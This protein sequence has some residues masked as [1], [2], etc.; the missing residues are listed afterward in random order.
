MIIKGFRA[1]V[2]A[3]VKAAN[4]I[5]AAF[6]AV[7]NVIL[8][9][10]NLI[11]SAFKKVAHAIASVANGIVRLFAKAFGPIFNALYKSMKPGLDLLA[12]AFTATG[13]GIIKAHFG[14]RMRF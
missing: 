11:A 4:T 8:A 6:N 13:N 9:C 7:K 14:N 1:I 5:K 2:N 3:I 12:K 10:G